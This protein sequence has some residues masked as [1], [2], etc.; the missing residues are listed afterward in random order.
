MSRRPC[1]YSLP[2]YTPDREIN[3]SLPRHHI[4]S[5]RT[6]PLDSTPY[7]RSTRLQTLRFPQEM[8]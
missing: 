5:V 2:E 3:S 7:P 8:T 1:T 4:R 6:M